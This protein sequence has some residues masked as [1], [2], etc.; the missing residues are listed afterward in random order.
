VVVNYDLPRSPADYIHRIG[1]TGRAGES[2]V[3]VTLVNHETEAHLRLIEKKNQI[4]LNRD[5]VA[6]FEL[7][8]EPLPKIKNAGPIKGKRK[9]KKDK[10]REQKAKADATHNPAE[11]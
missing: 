7:S 8:G 1:R 2:G 3:S 4:V 5:E 11:H 9:S 6:G 10:L